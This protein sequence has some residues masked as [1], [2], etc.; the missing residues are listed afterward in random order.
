MTTKKRKSSLGVVLLVAVLVILGLVV[1]RLQDADQP[2]SN[3]ILQ[4]PS[5]DAVAPAPPKEKRSPNPFTGA[6]GVSRIRR[7]WASFQAAQN[8]SKQTETDCTTQF[9]CAPTERCLHGKCKGDIR[10][11]TDDK[12]CNAG[13]RCEFSQ[14][15]QGKREC[16]SAPDCPAKYSCVFGICAYGTTHCITDVQCSADER[17]EFFRCFQGE[18]E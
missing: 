13:E 9:D 17:C 12:D 6:R 3:D 8:R 4:P 2:D 7:L 11:C 18:R 10:K 15:F 5:V 16:K 1:Y 14:C